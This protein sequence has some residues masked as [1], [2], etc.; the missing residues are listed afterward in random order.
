MKSA[1][2][3]N[4]NDSRVG[5][6]ELRKGERM[7]MITDRGRYTFAIVALR[8]LSSEISVMSSVFRAG[9]L[10]ESAAGKRFWRPLVVVQ[11]LSLSSRGLK[12]DHRA[13]INGAKVEDLA[14]GSGK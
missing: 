9:K 6:R 14:C 13:L 8:L 3:D 11:S 7:F 2:I 5:E 10:W 12:H 4:V 1:D